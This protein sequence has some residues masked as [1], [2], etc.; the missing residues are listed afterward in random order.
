LDIENDDIRGAEAG[1]GPTQY[2]DADVLVPESEIGTKEDDERITLT[3]I[4][5]GADSMKQEKCKV[6]KGNEG[7]TSNE[8]KDTLYIDFESSSIAKLKNNR[9]AELKRENKSLR[10]SALCN[11]CL[12]TYVTP[13]VSTA[14]WHVHCEQ[15]WL[16][17]LGAK[18]LCPQCKIIV[19]PKDLR[20]I[21]L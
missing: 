19:Q 7:T 15:C 16:R 18:K 8:C 9:I 5:L 10:Q 3:Q 20:K 13:V 17:A 4:L 14:C 11:I 6:E 1:L 21:Y 2:T 12:T